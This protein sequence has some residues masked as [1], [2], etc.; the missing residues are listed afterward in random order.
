MYTIESLSISRLLSSIVIHFRSIVLIIFSLC[1]NLFTGHL[2]RSY[3][4]IKFIGI[5]IQTYFGIITGNHYS[6]VNVAD[7]NFS[8]GITADRL[9]K[10]NN[11]NIN[12]DYNTPDIF[13]VFHIYL[14]KILYES[15][16]VIK[17]QCIDWGFD[18]DSIKI[19]TYI[20]NQDLTKYS[21]STQAAVIN[22]K[23]SNSIIIAFRGTEPM[24]LL[25]WITDASTNFIDINNI[26]NDIINKNPIQVHAGFYSA[27]G[28][29]ELK[30]IHEIDFNNVN[31][32]T[33]PMFIQLL[34]AIKEFNQNDT[35]C[36]IT[37][38][39]HSLGA[40][41]AS[42]FSFVLAGYGY[43]SCISGVYTY[44]QPLVG[45]RHYAEILNNKLGNR[46]HRW[47][48]HSD[49]VPR[50][51]VIELPS[52]PWFYART[53]Y[54][55]ALEVATHNNKTKSNE[56]Q[57]HYYHSGLRFKIDWKGNL[58]R[59]NLIDQGPILAYQDGLD[60]FYIKYS[61]FNA[62][63][64]LCNITPLRSLLWLTAPAEIND[65]FPGDYGRRIKKIVTKNK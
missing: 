39:G 29:H 54:S 33:T 19:L 4:F 9:F 7:D 64:S 31:D 57:H 35:K 41:L 61:F 10:K 2:Y 47:V 21:F 20:Q 6:L 56:F 14:S 11:N 51:P 25:Q 45:N 37:I 27:L 58:V 43:E 8:I 65:H 38:T 26:F 36:N 34:K 40:G 3:Q 32:A 50:L 16:P 44:G 63:Y 46:I 18:D 24:D 15:S 13:D 48:N 5:Y 53:R 30:P 17:Q 12:R 22:Y 49:I 62:I 55:D 42:L 23:E 1:L 59:E 52:I 28:L 60:L